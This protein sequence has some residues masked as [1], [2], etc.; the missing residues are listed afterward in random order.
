MNW[1]ELENLILIIYF[2]GIEK[3][4]TTKFLNTYGMIATLILL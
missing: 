3:F 2:T 4:D 1:V